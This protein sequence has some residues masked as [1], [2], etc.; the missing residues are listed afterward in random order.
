MKQVVLKPLYH[1]GQESIGIYYKKD[2]SLS[3][4]VR[5]LS[6]AKWSQSNRCWYVPLN[7]EAY[8]QISNALRGEVSLYIIRTKNLSR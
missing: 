8:K 3:L 4:L 6:S 7:A 2:A 5:K 1:R